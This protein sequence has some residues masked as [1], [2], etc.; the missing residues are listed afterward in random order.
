VFTKVYINNII[1]F[2]ASLLK[3]L[4]YLYKLFI[5]FYNK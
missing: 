4:T 1:A 3:Y 5:L 2:L